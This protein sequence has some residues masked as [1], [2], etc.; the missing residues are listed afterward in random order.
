VPASGVPYDIQ[1]DDPYSIFPELDSDI[2]VR[3]N[4]EI[5]D[6]YLI[7][8][9]EMRES[10]RILRQ[11]LPRLEQTQAEPIISGTKQYASRVPP[12]ESYGHAE[13]LKGELGFYVASAGDTKGNQN[14]WSYHVRGASFAN[15][16]ALGPI[17]VGH[18]V[19][20]AIGILGSIDI[21]LGEVDR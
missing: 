21:V 20:D 19:A 1:R 16:T 17:C 12:G 15:L 10:L 5:Y 9:D 4:G 6:R 7:R 2:A 18:K 13:N 11:I 14:P 3:P 8:L